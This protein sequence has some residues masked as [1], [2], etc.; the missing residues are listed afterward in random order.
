MTNTRT[1]PQPVDATPDPL[2]LWAVPVADLGGVARHVLDVA[3]VGLPGL[4]LAVLCPEGP[5]AERLRALGAAVFVGPFGPDD[6][7]LASVR[8]L[9]R[10][11][12]TLRPAVVHTHL[13]Y[14]DIVAGIA[15]A[16]DRKVGL[17]SSE[18]GIAPDDALYNAGPATAKVTNLAHRGRLART[19]RVIAVSESTKR[20]LEAKWRPR[21]PVTVVP[22]GVDLDAVRAA[23]SAE[24]RTVGEGLRVLSL[25]RLSPEKGLDRLVAAMPLLLQKDPQARLTLAGTGPLA[26]QLQSQAGRLG[27][28]DAV[29][30]PGFVE[31]WHTMAQHDVLVQLSCW[32]NLSYTLLDAAAA[33]LPALATDVGGN[34]EILPAGA[35]LQDPTPEAIVTGVEKVVAG[36]VGEPHVTGR[37]QMVAAIARVTDEVRAEMSR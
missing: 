7:T 25:S 2:T 24:R 4:R 16:G 30:L 23:A 3:A 12:G 28:G 5:L 34:G 26:G 20:V 29:D 19:Q 13:A 15:L 11:V 36:A 27:V 1:E 17:I 32:E 8:T 35:L 6:G 9:R 14:A 18:H 37:E 10:L 33:G 22:N 31:P 21:C